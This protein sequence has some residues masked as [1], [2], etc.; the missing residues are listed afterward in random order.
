MVAVELGLSCG[1]TL[2]G[3]QGMVGVD[4]TWLKIIS[5]TKALMVGTTK[6]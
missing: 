6:G 5:P 3:A 4:K 2:A 1:R